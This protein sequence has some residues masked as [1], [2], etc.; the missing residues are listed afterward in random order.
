MPGKLVIKPAETAAERKAYIH[1]MWEVYKGDPYWVPPLISERIEFLDPEKHPFHQ[2]AKVRYFT[3]QRDG[4]I[5]GTIA[6]IINYNHN[7]YWDDKVGFFGLFEVLK[8]EE[9]AHAL[10][11]AAADFVRSEGMDTLRG[12]M[13]F[14]TN[15][16]CGLL[17]DGWNG[18]PVA[19]LTYNP[20]YYA[21]F[22]ESAGF[23]KAHDLYAYLTD[24]SHVKP[25]G[26]GFNPKVLRVAEK[27]RKR[28]EGITFRPIN[29]RDFNNEARLF[30]KVYN[31][32][33][34]KNWGFVPLT[35]A[36]LA[37][38]IKALKPIIDPPTVVFVEKDGKAIGASLPLPDV[39]QALHRAYPR[40][41]VP[42]WWSLAKM[43]YWWKV[44]KCVTTLRAFAGGFLEEYRGSGLVAILALE[45]LRVA[46]QRGYTHAEFSWVLE[47]NIPMRQ[48]AA[49]FMGQQYR[50]YRI[51][52][53]SVVG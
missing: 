18:T 40:P 14:S 27:V 6:G 13:N 45:D 41:G 7:A 38:E 35:E 25:D 9:A 4:K 16:E 43:M 19:M 22:I 47:S 15:E 21:D 12:P 10:L 3:A 48:T 39:N 46:V 37:H 26:T 44:R 28:L 17:V 34:S 23:V 8:D 24:L 52:D 42:D 2:H 50:T 31:Q 29:M 33:W 53:K 32:A 30:K 20:P 11:A 36:E 51:Y 5:V 49:N 1:F